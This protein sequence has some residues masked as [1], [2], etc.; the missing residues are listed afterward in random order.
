MIPV[1]SYGFKIFYNFSSVFLFVSREWMFII[2]TV[3]WKD[4]FVTLV[5]YYIDLKVFWP[6]SRDWIL[7]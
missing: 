7:D 2:L 1:K 6:L 4:V 5:Y 3:D